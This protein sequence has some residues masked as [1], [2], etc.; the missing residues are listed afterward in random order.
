V[1]AVTAC[2]R[3][4]GESTPPKLPQPVSTDILDASCPQQ[5]LTLRRMLIRENAIG[6]ADAERDLPADGLLDV[7]ESLPPSFVASH[8]HQPDSAPAAP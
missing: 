7:G 1:T 2:L 6:Q 3:R 8:F 4:V 5:F